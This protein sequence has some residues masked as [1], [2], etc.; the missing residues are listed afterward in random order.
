[1]ELVE[2]KIEEIKLLRGRL[3]ILPERKYTTKGLIIIPT[4]SSIA[5]P[6][7]RIGKI[8]LKSQEVYIYDR[9]TGNVKGTGRNPFFKEQKVL[10]SYDVDAQACIEPIKVDVNGKKVLMFI[11][12]VGL[13]L[14]TLE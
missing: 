2:A 1:M 5:K 9:K 10:F 11:I 8:I 3:L 6:L 13:V 4:Y 12:P 7:Y 14:A